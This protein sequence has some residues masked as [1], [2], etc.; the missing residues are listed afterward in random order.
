MQKLKMEDLGKKE[1]DKGQDICMHIA[2]AD[3]MGT[4]IRGVKLEDTTTYIGSMHKGLPT[5]LQEKIGTGHADW[6]AFLQVL[7]DIDINYICNGADIWKKEQA[8]QEAIKR[9]LQQL[10]KLTASPTAPL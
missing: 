4:I 1:K 9:H 2:W 3:K 5:L 8:D 10:E 7:R 6:T